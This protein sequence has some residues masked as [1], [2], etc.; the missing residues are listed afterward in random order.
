MINNNQKK[1]NKSSFPCRIYVVWLLNIHS[2][3]HLQRREQVLSLAAELNATGTEYVGL[4]QD[5]QPHT[6]ELT[7]SVGQYSSEFE[8][9]KRKTR[10]SRGPVC[11][12]KPAT[13][14]RPFPGGT[15][16]TTLNSLADSIRLS[17]LSDGHWGRMSKSE[18][19]YA[20]VRLPH[21][22]SLRTLW[23][24]KLFQT[25]QPL[26]K[27]LAKMPDFVRQLF[28]CCTL[29]G[30][31]CGHACAVAVFAGWKYTNLIAKILCYTGSL[32]I[33]QSSFDPVVS[34]FFRSLQWNSSFTPEALP[35]LQSVATTWDSLQTTTRQTVGWQGEAFGRGRRDMFY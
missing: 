2:L 29:W 23:I 33:V 7:E 19:L 20:F 30:H 6:E 9:G 1:W 10:F 14:R 5:E 18:K 32:L 8:D 28:C 11:R 17:N 15:A 21:E 24:K 26:F 12:G 35:N 3:T 25:D 22:L 4:K 13:V 27:V 31:V 34:R 16:A